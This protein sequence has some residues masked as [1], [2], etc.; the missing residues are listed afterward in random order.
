MRRRN[1]VRATALP[2]GIILLSVMSAAA[3]EAKE[4]TVLQ[5]PAGRNVKVGKQAGDTLRVGERVEVYFI[6]QPINE[7]ARKATGR[8]AQ[9]EREVFYVAL[10]T[11]SVSAPVAAGDRVSTLGG[12]RAPEAPV[13]PQPELPPPEPVW[14]SPATP[15]PGPSPLPQTG[16][17]YL[18]V[19]LQDDPLG[20]MVHKVAPNTAAA[21]AGFLAG[22]IIYAYQGTTIRSVIQFREVVSAASP[23]ATARFQV[24]RAGIEIVLS[25]VLGERPQTPPPIDLPPV[26]PA[27]PV[28]TPP[29]T[30]ATPPVIPPAQPGTPWQPTR[31]P[32]M[33]PLQPSPPPFPA[34]VAGPQYQEYFTAGPAS[35]LRS[36]IK[37]RWD[38]GRRITGI[39]HGTRAWFLIATADSAVDQQQW[40]LGSYGYVSNE[41]AKH[42]RQGKEITSIHCNGSSWLAMLSTGTS[43][44]SQK[45]LARPLLVDVGKE[46][47]DHWDQGYHVTGL[48]HGPSGWF[49]V[50]SKGTGYTAQSYVWRRSFGDMKRAITEKWNQGYHVTD[51]LVDKGVW[52]AIFSKGS[53]YTAQAWSS[54]SNYSAFQKEIKNRWSQGYRVTSITYDNQ[55][56]F[57]MFAKGRIRW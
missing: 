1:T 28:T 49:L 4:W 35:A 53:G 43:L 21:R 2:A 48:S 52:L 54:R 56:W 14:L 20:V 13:Q 6:I 18:G 15:A 50:F 41:I 32:A 27:P 22:D 34:P 55:A 42:W 24:L 30:P 16:A 12:E 45:H 17:G 44:H 36:S 57:A 25:A 46:I 8:I 7:R 5:A 39:T 9:V 38:A 19:V 37:Q 10:D 11:D 51:I 29:W 3:S 40:I 47:R 26:Q 23:G 31:P 33:P